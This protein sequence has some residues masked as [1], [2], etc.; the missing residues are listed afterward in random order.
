MTQTNESSNTGAA[1]TVSDYDAIC[2]VAQLCTE[3]E[4]TG[5]AAGCL[6]PGHR[7]PPTRAH[8]GDLEDR[9][10][11]VRSHRWGTPRMCK[12]WALSMSGFN[13]AIGLQP[14]EPNK[15][16]RDTLPTRT[17]Y[18]RPP[19]TRFPISLVGI[20]STGLL[21]VSFDPEVLRARK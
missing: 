21:V 17:G 12:G 14:S 9:L 20:D 1:G 8:R 3:G 16:T 6:S 13:F 15:H 5:E 7:L 2:R 18:F 10:Q 11:A 4:A 19:M